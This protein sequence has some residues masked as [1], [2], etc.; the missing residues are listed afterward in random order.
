MIQSMDLVTGEVEKGQGKE[1]S[2]NSNQMQS[3]Q[4]EVSLVSSS[5]AVR[6][7]VADGTKEEDEEEREQEE[8]KKKKKNDDGDDNGYSTCLSQQDASIGI[9]PTP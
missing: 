7:E 3:K 2:P 4:E 8:K 6:I 9:A 1:S 5:L